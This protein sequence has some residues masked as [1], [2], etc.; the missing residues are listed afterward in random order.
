MKNIKIIQSEIFNETISNLSAAIILDEIKN[1]QNLT[2]RKKSCTILD[3]I[4][5]N[6]VHFL[7]NKISIFNKLFVKS[8]KKIKRNFL[9]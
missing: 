6:D 4:N 5:S 1:D 8:S 2:K 3:Q 9:D 7:Y